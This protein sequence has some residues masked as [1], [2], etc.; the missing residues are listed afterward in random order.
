M[1]L[2]FCGGGS[3]VATLGCKGGIWDPSVSSFSSEVIVVLINLRGCSF[4]VLRVVLMST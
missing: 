3:V 1:T 4:N 2:D